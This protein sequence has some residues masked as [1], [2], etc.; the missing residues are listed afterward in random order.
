MIRLFLKAFAI[1]FGAVLGMIVV[2]AAFV[3]VLVLIDSL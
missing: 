3:G 1:A 2:T